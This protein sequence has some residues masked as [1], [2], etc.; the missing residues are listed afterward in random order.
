MSLLF[1]RVRAC[2]GFEWVNSVEAPKSS[3]YVLWCTR[4]EPLET[5]YESPGTFSHTI[6]RGN[7]MSKMSRLVKG[8]IYYFSYFCFYSV[9]LA[10]KSSL[11]CLFACGESGILWF[12]DCRFCL[13]SRMWTAVWRFYF[14]VVLIVLFSQAMAERSFYFVRKL[15]ESVC[16]DTRCS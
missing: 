4:L 2:G 3:K 9:L 1:A 6:C 13:L 15:F 12:S 7:M 14:G 11:C 10:S 8:L 16:I 5:V